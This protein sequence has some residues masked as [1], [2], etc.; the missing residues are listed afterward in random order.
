MMDHNC[1]VPCRCQSGSAPYSGS[2]WLL[3]VLLIF[4]PL[5]ADWDLDHGLPW[6]SGL[7]VWTRAAAQHPWA[8]VRRMADHK[9]SEAPQSQE[10]ISHNLPFSLLLVQFL[11]R[12][13]TDTTVLL[14]PCIYLVFSFYSFYLSFR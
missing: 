3:G 11:W 9:A 6:F 12:V 4:G 1:A 2:I 14:K 13:L 10:P 7:W 5:D 8:S